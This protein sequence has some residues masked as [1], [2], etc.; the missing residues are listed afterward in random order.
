MT[1]KLNLTIEEKTAKRIKAYAQ[2]RKISVSKIAEEYFDS[3]L[4]KSHNNKKGKS[5]VERAAGVIKD[6]SI[7]NID[8]E[9]DNYLKEKYGV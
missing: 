7:N 8:K 5:F 1:T 9:R 4:K 2:K 3:L 6:I